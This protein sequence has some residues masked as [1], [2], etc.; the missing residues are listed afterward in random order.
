MHVILKNYNHGT[1]S[2][3]KNWQILVFKLVFGLSSMSVSCALVIG[4]E[5][6]PLRNHSLIA[7]RSYVKPSMT[8]FRD[9]NKNADMNK[10]N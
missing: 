9:V 2:P 3:Y 5:N 8:E 10:K 1:F 7:A 6:F 4:L